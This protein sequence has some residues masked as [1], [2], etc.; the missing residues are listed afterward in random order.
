MDPQEQ[1]DQNSSIKDKFEDAEY[2]DD[3]EDMQTLDTDEK[4]PQQH[5]G[6]LEYCLAIIK[7]NFC[8]IT[9]DSLPL[10]NDEV[11][12]YINI[13]TVTHDKLPEV[14]TTAI[15]MVP[16]KVMGD[17]TTIYQDNICLYDMCHVD[18]EQNKTEPDESIF[19]GIATHLMIDNKKV[20]GTVVILRSLLTN[21]K[22]CEPANLT[23]EHI[24]DLLKYKTLH[25]GLFVPISGAITEYQFYLDPVED[26][27][28]N[29]MKN[30]GYVETTISKFNLL[31]FFPIDDADHKINKRATRLL[32]KKVYGDVYIASRS[33]EITYEDLTLDLYGKLDKI[34]WG[35]S[36]NRDLTEEETKEG[37]ENNGMPV[38]INRYCI[39]ESRLQTNLHVCNNCGKSDMDQE[40]KCTGC[41]RVLYDSKQCQTQDWIDH[42]KDCL[43]KRESVNDVIRQ[44]RVELTEQD[45]SLS[46]E[47]ENENEKTFDNL[48]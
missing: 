46:N 45:I 42:R 5:F 37:E 35:H 18:P 15:G 12:K 21:D 4:H 30:M 13:A 29:V 44:K 34:S 25:T 39:L 17:T 40:L 36:K 23:I 9:K 31:T 26:V 1:I 20:Y 24:I 47:N 38:I 27:D 11:D 22:T 41:Y 48:A 7:P 6:T 19:N 8:K 10:L 3:F 28:V 14:I 16:Q 2:I 43:Y 32:N 33:T